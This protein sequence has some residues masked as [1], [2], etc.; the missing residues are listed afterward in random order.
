MFPSRYFARR[1]YA[2]TYFPTTETSGTGGGY[3]PDR[4]FPH[5][6]FCLRYFPKTV[7]ETASIAIVCMR[8]KS[9]WAKVVDKVARG[10]LPDKDCCR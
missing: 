1:Y 10:N 9:I 7:T 8:P 6:M 4:Y 3:F 2:V 5:R